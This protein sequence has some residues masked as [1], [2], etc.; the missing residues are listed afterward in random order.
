MSNKQNFLSIKPEVLSQN[1]NSCVFTF[2]LIIL[3]ELN[4]NQHSV[5]LKPNNLLENN[6]KRKKLEPSL[7]ANP[8][9]RKFNK[10]IQK[11]HFLRYVV[12]IVLVQNLITV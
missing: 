3:C 12:C 8:L 11:I 2:Y 9:N 1:A 10:I 4:C 5:L 6:I 7:P